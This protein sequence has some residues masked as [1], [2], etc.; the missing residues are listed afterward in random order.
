ME[1]TRAK[2]IH[3]SSS[4]DLAPRLRSLVILNP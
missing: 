1:L 4:A 3:V 2:V